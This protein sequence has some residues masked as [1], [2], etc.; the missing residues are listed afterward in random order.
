MTWPNEYD[1]KF[2]YLCMFNCIEN[3]NQSLSSSTPLKVAKCFVNQESKL[4]HVSTRAS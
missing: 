1:I 2:V 4:I 3:R